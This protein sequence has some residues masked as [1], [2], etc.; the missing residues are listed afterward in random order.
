MNGS[1][2]TKV[3][4]INGPQYISAYCNNI[5]FQVNSLDLVLIFGESIDVEGDE[6]IVEKKARITFTPQQIKMLQYIVNEQIAQYEALTGKP[7]ELPPAIQDA[8]DNRILSKIE[9]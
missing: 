8:V 2:P 9:G 4:Y 5:A 6:A 1:N 3:R 7:I